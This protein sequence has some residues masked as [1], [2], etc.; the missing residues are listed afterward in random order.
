MEPSIRAA[1][2]TK[3]FKK[4]P[5]KRFLTLKSQLIRDLWGRKVEDNLFWA[6]RGVDLEVPSGRSVG[7]IGTNGSGKSTLLKIMAGILKPTAGT[8]SVRGRV[9]ALIE[10]GAGFHPEISGRENIFINGIMLGLTKREIQA[11]YN[12]I[13]RFSELEEFIDNPVKSYS[14][15]MYMRLGF[16]VAVHVDPDVLLIDEVLAVGDQA[17]GYKCIDRIL[18]FKRRNKTILLVTHNLGA[19]EKLCDEAVWIQDG[20]VKDRGAPRRVIDQ[21]LIFVNEREEQRL[22]SYHDDVS[23]T[24]DE[25]P[26][27]G[28]CVTLEGGGEICQE[29]APEKTGEQRPDARTRWGS[30]EV[31]IHQVKLLD[32]DGKENYVYRTGDSMTVKFWYRVRKPIEEPVFGIG[33]YM[34]TGLC[35]YG[36]N[37]QLEKLRLADIV[38]D[39]VVTIHIDRL[40]LV[41]GTYSLDVAVHAEDGY[42]YDYHCHLYTF[43]IRSATGDVGI[44]RPPHAWRFEPELRIENA[45]QVEDE[46]RT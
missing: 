28:G 38:E 7:I 32:A 30:R 45:G 18:D 25:P 1:G 5:H 33:I 15:G 8:V 6:L 31:E 27:P 10:L 43:A 40:D 29:E 13:V 12:D 19:V 35:V 20:I 22:A 26:E 36:S 3:C 34:Q 21:Y 9:S 11:R 46:D 44:Y 39:G 23:A 14:S 2:V 41:E 42:P 17:F 16:A 4:S 37:T 24:M